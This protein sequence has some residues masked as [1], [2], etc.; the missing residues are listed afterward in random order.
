MP[1]QHSWKKRGVYR[2]LTGHITGQELIRA[3]EEVVV[4]PDFENFRWVINDFLE[5]TD[6]SVTTDDIEYLAAINAAASLT[7]PRIS[8]AVVAS[9]STIR[10]LAELFDTKS[11]ELDS[12]YETRVFF[13]ADEAKSWLGVDD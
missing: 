3:V 10:V 5:M 12:A 4:S 8:I 9:E 1:I 11:K 2:K 7:N 6:H 13:S